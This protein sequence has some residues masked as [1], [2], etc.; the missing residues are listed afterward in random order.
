MSP[1]SPF[2]PHD[3]AEIAD[4]LRAQSDTGS[5]VTLRGGG[6]KATFGRPPPDDAIA[7]ELAEIAG[8]TLYEPDELVLTAMAGT[9]MAEIAAAV[10]ERDQC[11]AFEPPEF[12]PL[13]GHNAASTLGGSVASGWSGPRRIR[14]GATRDH[15][16][17]AQA[18][19]GDGQ[20]FKSGGR[21][22]KNVTGF[23]LPKLLTGSHGTLAVLTEITIKVMPA[24]EATHTMIVQGLDDTAAIRLMN[25]LMG[26]PY[27]IAAAAHLPAA[28][29]AR[30]G[31]AALAGASATLVRLEGFGPSV[32]D[33]RAAL[34]ARIGTLHPFIAAESQ[35]AGRLWQSVRDVAPLVPADAVLWRLALPAT[36]AAATVG[37]L[38]AQLP[39]EAYYDWG[40][41]LVWLALPPAADAH[42]GL[43]R[44]ALPAG[45]ATLMR[46][47][48]DTRRTVPVFQPQ[49]D[50]LAA[51]SRRVKA[52]FDPR[53]ILAPR[54]MHGEA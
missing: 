42:A 5:P 10:A 45:H 51:L 16:L 8:I 31:M 38:A 2:R 11:L 12:G 30:L 48:A 9:S 22:V 44:G 53:G 18:I 29:A 21:V 52:A 35:Q 14:A 46:A 25:D 41:G 3:A 47:S 15:V 24:A 33:R 6:S 1:L 50:A 19:G 40:G 32:A 36:D 49:P 54:F 28:S 39:V 13:F 20:L 23:D 37:S 17:G 27:E 4:F 34:E 26:G 7:V 43:V